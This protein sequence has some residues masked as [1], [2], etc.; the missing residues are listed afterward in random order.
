MIVDDAPILI[1]E[2][3]QPIDQEAF[4]SQEYEMPGNKS[5]RFAIFPP[6]FYFG[7]EDKRNALNY[8]AHAKDGI[9]FKI[10]IGFEIKDGNASILVICNSLNEIL[11][12]SKIYKLSSTIFCKKNKKQKDVKLEAKEVIIKIPLTQKQKDVQFCLMNEISIEVAP[13]YI[14]R[15]EV[16]FTGII[17]NAATCYMNSVF[18]ILFNLG[19][20]QRLV[21]SIES[22]QHNQFPCTLQS[23]FYNLKHSKIAI[24][25]QEIIKSFKW[26]VDQQAIQQDVQEFIMELLK[27]LGTKAPQIEN[28]INHLFQGILENHIKNQYFDNKNQEQ[29]MDIS[30]NITNSL[31]ES[32]DMFVEYE[33]L[34]AYIHEEFGKQEAIKFHKFKKLPPII[35]INLKR[36]Q[37]DG[38][39]FT[40]IHD[41]FQY[42]NVINF[43]DYLI[44]EEDKY[45]ELYAVLVHRGEAINHGHYYCYI[46]PFFQSQQWFKFD[47]KFVTR[48]TQKEVFQNNFGGQYQLPEYN[49]DLGEVIVEN[50]NN[51]ETAYMLVYLDRNNPDLQSQPD[52]FPEWILQQEQKINDLQFE[53][54]NYVSTYLFS[55][56]H[57]NLNQ[58]QQIKSGIIFHR[59]A[60][61]QSIDFNAVEEFFDQYTTPLLVP[62][63][64]T[65]QQ[66]IDQLC[67]KININ[68][69]NAH[70][71]IYR[72]TQL[73]PNLES[74]VLM[75]P[76]KQLTFYLANKCYQMGL[77]L[78]SI[79]PEDQQLIN[80]YLGLDKIKLEQTQQNC[81]NI[82]EQKVN[83]NKLII[84][85]KT[86]NNLVVSFKQVLLLDKEENMEHF[87]MN[88]YNQELKVNILYQNDGMQIKQS[89]KFKNTE[90]Y[91]VYLDYEFKFQAKIFEIENM[92]EVLIRV[93][94]E[95]QCISQLFN[96]NDTA[97][98]LLEYLAQLEDCHPDNIQIKYKDRKGNY[99]VLQQQIIIDDIIQYDNSIAYKQTV[100][101]V[102]AMK[103]Q[104]S[105]Q[106][107][108]Q[109]YIIQKSMSFGE[110]ME[111][112]NLKETV[113]LLTSKKDQKAAWVLLDQNA[114]ISKT[115]S[116]YN[117]KFVKPL[118]LGNEVYVICFLQSVEII[119]LC[120]PL[121]VQIQKSCTATELINYIIENLN[122]NPIT[123][124]TQQIQI[125]QDGIYSTEEQ[126]TQKFDLQLRIKIN[127]QE[128]SQ[129]IAVQ[130][131]S[132]FSEEK[133]LTLVMTFLTIRDTKNDKLRQKGVQIL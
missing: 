8:I 77:M 116:K 108:N 51:P 62:K 31:R 30:L 55:I 100:V 130:I 21:Y 34:D 103:E 19:I 61:N 124:K 78:I 94:N 32:L 69:S 3:A 114:K 64:I 126:K 20:F 17:N 57:L 71:L 90:Y 2:I 95:N 16:G 38:Q 101:P 54:K 58:K 67:E 99:Q 33:P 80:N 45:Y 118:I 132:L 123:Y 41:S 59:Q 53:Q 125:N 79:N 111:Q 15:D 24:S 89:S 109:T 72:I 66:I 25:T 23:L 102:G 70:L 63:T 44:D 88:Q 121:I 84:F 1:E 96:K 56:N 60:S 36:Y 50:K 76:Q 104:I 39:G 113:P 97:Q 75:Q 83:E 22:E 93:V 28:E 37:F 127:N 106:V 115:I 26:D 85:I 86:V 48:A 105:F 18:Q 10:Q 27:A 40:K 117:L 68:K 9:E 74:V 128:I 13:K 42:D 82:K 122:Q 107:D 65:I 110:F 131:G 120:N 49:E 7:L 133:Q 12:Q 91:Q 14:S 29:F 119:L 11:D 112:E 43:K 92:K 87:I 73:K 98:Q 47:D 5:S 35:L 46:K 4:L 6:H 81:K 52:K 129:D